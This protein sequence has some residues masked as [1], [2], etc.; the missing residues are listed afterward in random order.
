MKK[1]P[2]IIVAVICLVSALGISLNARWLYPDMSIDMEDSSV[3]DVNVSEFEYYPEIVIRKVTPISSSVSY[4]NSYYRQPSKVDSTI[5]GNSGS[6]VVYRIDARNYSETET[7]VYSGAV[8][9]S[10]VYSTFN[11]IELS[12][13]T[14]ENCNNLLNNNPSS[15]AQTGTLIAPGEDFVFYVKYSLTD[16]VSLGT[17]VINYIFRPVTYSVTYLHNNQEFAI[18]HIVDNSKAY[19]LIDEKPTQSGASF[20]GWVNVNGVVVDSIPKGNTHNYTLSASWDKIY[21][22]IFAD[23]QGNVLYQE[24]FTSS[25]TALSQQGQAT[26]DQILADLN[27]EAE[28]EHMTVSWSEYTIKGSKQDIMVK[29]IYAYNGILNLRPM[30]DEPDDGIVDYY[31]VEAVDSL[32]ETV[33]VPGSVGGVPVKVVKRITNIDGDQDWNNFEKNVTTIIIEEGVESLGDKNDKDHNGNALAWTPNLATVKLPS[34]L[35]Y[36]GKNTFSRNIA[37]GGFG[38]GDDKKVLTIEFNGTKTQWKALISKSDSSWDG[39]LKDGSVVKCTDG[40]FELDKGVFSSSWK[41]KSY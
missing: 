9:D 14:D 32:P 1:I 13:S 10:N 40:Y 19:S 36:L 33:I 3:I 5:T 30:Y 7:F 38:Y 4:E 34:T 12:V 25:S 37:L 8:C 20:V 24:Q 15:V 31:Q 18:E 6:E 26:V 39:G 23:A 16:D 41:E 21:L 27:A 35:T 11:H 2:L 17:L 22:I 28:K 29:A